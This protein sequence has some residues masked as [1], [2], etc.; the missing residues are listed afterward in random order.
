M[1]PL[2]LNANAQRIYTYLYISMYMPYMIHAYIYISIYSISFNVSLTL[3]KSYSKPTYAHL[4]TLRFHSN[5]FE[6]FPF[7]F[8]LFYNTYRS[9]INV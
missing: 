5:P 9:C 7:R 3:L 8:Y 4:I 1:L 6:M 2:T